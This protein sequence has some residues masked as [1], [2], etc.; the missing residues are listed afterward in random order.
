MPGLQGF[1]LQYVPGDNDPS[2]S[3]GIFV[4]AGRR[5]NLPE[6]GMRV[7]VSG[8]VVEF[9]RAGSAGSL[10]EIDLRS[11]SFAIEGRGE[12]PLPVAVDPV[13][14]DD[15]EPYEGMLIVYPPS[16]VLSPANRFGEFFVLRGD[17][18]SPAVRWLPAS[19]PL[20]L[21][22]TIGSAGG[23]LRRDP[24]TFDLLPPLRG[25]LHFDFGLFRLEPVEPYE[26]ADAGFAPVAAPPPGEASLR[27]A[28]LNCQ[29]LVRDL[30]PAAIELKIAKLALAIREP[31]RSPELIGVAEVEDLELL[32][33]LA[34]RAG[35]YHAVL[36][37]GCDFGRINVGLL[38]SSRLSKTG[39]SQLQTEAPEF[40][41]GACTLPDG[42]QFAQFLFDRP[43]LLVDFA[44]GSL[45]FSVLVNHWR[46]R[47][48]GRE[49]ERL[50]SA[51]YLAQELTRLGRQNL[52]VLGDFNDTEDS[53]PLLEL[54]QKA[55]LTPLAWQAPEESRYSFLFEGRSEALDHILLSPTLA[56]RVVVTGYAHF[57]AD[58]PVSLHEGALTPVR[59][60]DH[61]APFVYLK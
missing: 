43:P 5:D 13:R 39:Q 15:L 25:V 1:F 58:F 3:D 19:P 30:S 36:L 6:V 42:R 27:I 32:E 31:L 47:I 57:N 60:S 26:I 7:Q 24:K 18:L 12:L 37:G 29:R 10:T 40:G 14:V 54:G 9:S 46:S 33:L 35:D 50:A 22:I 52:V 55:G 2:T 51:R 48:G 44:F 59:A 49:A 16:T 45:Q 38:Y 61:D 17:R 21:P 11:G 20:G 23:A 4:F 53:P 28:F 41:N 34:A 56:A 8:P